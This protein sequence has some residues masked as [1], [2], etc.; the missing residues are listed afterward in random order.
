[1]L[2]VIRTDGKVFPY[3]QNVTLAG[4]GS[5]TVSFTFNMGMSQGTHMV[6]IDDLIER[7]SVDDQN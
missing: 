6:I 1:M 3:T 4:G 5:Q 7:L 2:T